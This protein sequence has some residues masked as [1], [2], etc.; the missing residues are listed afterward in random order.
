MKRNTTDTF[1]IP[2]CLA[3]KQKLETGHGFDQVF[4]I[5]RVEKQNTACTFSEQKIGDQSPD[6][7]GMQCEEVRV[8]VSSKV[9]FSK[10]TPAEQ[11]LRYL[12]QA[13][14][15]KKLRRKLRKYSGQKG[16]REDSLLQKAIEKIKSAKH[17]LDDQKM[18]VENLV[19]A[20]NTGKLQPN[21]LG[22][23]QVSTILRDV[24]GLA[25]PDSK[26]AITL[27]EKLIP[28]SSIEYDIYKKLPCTPGILRA[29][30]GREQKGVE[31]P[32]ELLRAL[33]IQVFAG[34]QEGRIEIYKG[35]EECPK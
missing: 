1:P 12:N 15:I 35:R 8:G 19:Q 9:N 28:I 23:N 7:L 31:D 3:N 26:F 4:S 33:H 10:L 20:I 29:M 21:T 2:D 5:A 32:S 17:E 13:Q 30:V 25:C 24:L 16:R 14:E 11:R 18:L 6:L 22:Y 34:I 27:P